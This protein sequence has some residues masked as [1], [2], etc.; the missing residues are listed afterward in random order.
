MTTHETLSPGQ[1]IQRALETKAWSQSDLAFALGTTNAAINQILS[2]KRGISHNMA[3]ALSVALGIPADEIVKHQAMWD[4]RQADE[5]DANV[6]SR[7]RILTQYPLRDM[8]KRGWIDPEDKSQSLEQ[9][10]CRFFS[11]PTLDDVPHLSHSAKK[12]DYDSIPPAQLAWLF[13][14]QQI[15]SEMVV[16]KFDKFKF[17]QAIEMLSELRMEAG[18]VR[19]VPKILASA[20][21]RFVVVES[22]PSS[23]IDG[24]CFWLDNNSPVIGL[25]LRFDR[26][27]NF[28]FVLRHECA[29]VFHGHGKQR[30]I[31]DVDVNDP[32][33]TL[34]S[35]EERIANAEAA[36]FCV[37]SAKI[38][39]FY[40]RKRPFFPDKEVVAFAKIAKTH[41]GLVVGQ[42]QR[43]MNRYDLL[44]QHLVK[45]K[46]HL[47][48]AMMFDGWGDV[49]PTER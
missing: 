18:L 25:S 38:D 23:K 37:P 13:R 3:R 44:R 22:L 29:H 9:Q 27:D 36:E 31:V 47:A 14:V 40:L 11:V 32:S 45:I 16:E 43:K 17:E 20:G 15:A 48:T 24:V 19:R 12:T 35:E 10:I 28:W 41:P 26:I 1:Y 33:A 8:I 49:V 7:S 6:K 21:V 46:D 30:P 39:S 4:M 42:L 2:D 34:V 5:P